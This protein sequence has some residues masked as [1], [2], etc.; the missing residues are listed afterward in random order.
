MLKVNEN[1]SYKVIISQ[2]TKLEKINTADKSQ[3][4]GMVWRITTIIHFSWEL[5]ICT[6]TLASNL[7][8]NLATFSEAHEQTLLPEVLLLDINTKE[9]L[10]CTKFSQKTALS[11]VR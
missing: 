11:H 7:A 10:T 1:F 4:L 6:T 5:K 8:S 3:V 9:T 2:T